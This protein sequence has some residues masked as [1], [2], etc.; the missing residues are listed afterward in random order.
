M[1]DQ[2]NARL[3]KIAYEAFLQSDEY[4]RVKSMII[5]DAFTPPAW[6]DLNLQARQAWIDVANAVVKFLTGNPIDAKKK[7]Y[8]CNGPDEQRC[9]VCERDICQ[10]CIA[11]DILPGDSCICLECDVITPNRAQ[12]HRHY[13]KRTRLKKDDVSN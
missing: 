10:Q 11:P 1:T 12:A 13:W 4:Q 3:A 8:L 6:D 2:E 5:I 7:C 9:I